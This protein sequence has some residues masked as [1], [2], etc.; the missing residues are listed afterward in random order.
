M[1]PDENR[2]APAWIHAAALVGFAAA[3]VLLTWPLTA[4]LNDAIP[5]AGAGDNVTFLWNF[6]WMRHALAT[7]DTFFHT[8]AL[9]YPIGVDLVVHTHTALNAFVGATLLGRLTVAE[10]QNVVIL[11]SYALNGFAAYI[12]AWTTTRR[13]S[14]SVVAGIVFMAS[15]YFTA[16]LHGHFNLTTAWFIPLYAAA[17]LA[18]LRQHRLLMSLLAGLTLVAATYSDYYYLVFLIFLTVVIVIMRWLSVTIETAEP[19]R[20]FV[21]LDWLLAIVAVLAVAA[22]VIIAT[23]GGG[24]VSLSGIRVS[25]TSGHNLRVGF[26]LAFVIL[27]WRRWRPSLRMSRAHDASPHRDAVALAVIFGVFALGSAPVLWLA[28]QQWLRGDYVSQIY[29]WRSMPAGIDLVSVVGGNPFHPL[30][31]SVVTRLY[32]ACGIDPIESSAWLGVVPIV[33][34]VAGRR[35]VQHDARLRFWFAIAATFFVWA[36]GP[37]LLVAGVNAGLWLPEVLLRFVPIASNARI[38]GRAMVMVY[39]ALAMICAIVVSRLSREKAPRI[40]VLALVVVGIDWLAVPFP[41][42]Q[43]PKSALYDE[44]AAAGTGAVLE[45]PLGL[46]DG[47]GERGSF[48]HAALY[49]QTIH[50]KPIAGGFIARLAPSVKRYYEEQPV[51]RTLLDLSSITAVDAAQ[52]P[53][54]TTI[55]AFLIEQQIRFVVVNSRLAPERLQRF[56]REQ[57]PVVLTKTE[58]ERQLYEVR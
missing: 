57:M 10:A 33:A 58:G 17:A 53:D 47:F 50:E 31:G 6:W 11:A 14:A 30:W 35:A 36:L 51:F 45:L 5:G 9:F 39:L 54:R 1:R 8:N 16:H 20:P 29:T 4:H 24:V 12:L 28:F 42:Y 56:V 55:E 13:M 21:T 32:D 41:L 52:T 26:W 18:A 27:A 38:P 25:L 46:R 7:P 34:L 49:Y 23:T 15:P 44:V 40:A 2:H 48:D 43:L 22:A 3:A 37:S 19:R